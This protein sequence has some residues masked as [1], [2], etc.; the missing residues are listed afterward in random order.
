MIAAG[1]PLGR[2]RRPVGRDRTCSTAGCRRCSP[3]GCCCPF[4]K[5]ELRRAHLP[6][7]D[8]SARLRCPAGP[9]TPRP[10]CTC[11][12]AGPTCGRGGV[13]RATGTCPTA[14][15]PGAAAGAGGPVR[16]PSLPVPVR[17]PRLHRTHRGGP[18]PRTLGRIADLGSAR[19]RRT[20]GR[21]RSGIDLFETGPHLLL[22]S[23]CRGD[24]DAPARRPPS[25]TGCS[26]RGSASSWWPRP[27]RHCRTLPAP[28]PTA[29]RDGG[30]QMRAGDDGGGRR[31]TRGR[32]DLRRP[33]G[34]RSWWTT[35]SRSPSSRPRRTGT[36]SRRCWPRSPTPAASAGAPSC[37]AGTPC[38]SCPA[39][40]VRWPGSSAR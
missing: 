9:W 35:A 36:I 31:T 25:R 4:P 38:R 40:G 32:G 10:G 7:P 34:S 6:R 13:A 5:E 28:I 22:V 14:G 2:A 1:P 3:G 17:S 8:A 39:S 23:G 16:F 24:R 19:C 11:R 21:S 12:C 26:P 15:P 27:V 20:A 37:C 18:A 29:R 30:V 33:G